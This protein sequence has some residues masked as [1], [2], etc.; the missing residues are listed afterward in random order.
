MTFKGIIKKETSNKRLVGLCLI[1]RQVIRSESRKNGRQCSLLQFE[2]LQYVKE[3]GN[4]L[5]N[6]IS[7]YFFITPSATTFLIDGLVKESFLVRAPDKNDRRIIRIKLTKKGNEFLEK[8]IKWKLEKLD[9]IFSVL[10]KPEKDELEK[11]LK[12]IIESKKR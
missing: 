12:K 4:P 5:T 11:I 3:N 7:R 10:S 8:E 1:M 6:D 2:T 9:E